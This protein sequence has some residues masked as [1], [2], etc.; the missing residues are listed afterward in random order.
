MNFLLPALLL[1]LSVF[2][3]TT[4]QTLV[5]ANSKKIFYVLS[6]DKDIKEG[7]YAE[8]NNFGNRL[9][10][11]GFY[12]NNQKDSLWKYY[13]FSNKIAETGFYKDDK[14]TG[15]WVVYNSKDKLE[16]Q[17]DYT[18]HKL[19]SYRPDSTISITEEV[20]N[21][22]DTIKKPLDQ[23]AIYMDGFARVSAQNIRYPAKAREDDIQGKVLIAFTVDALGGVSNFRVKKGI[24]GGCDEEALRVIK[25]M[26]GDWLP[27]IVNGKPVTI[28][29]TIPVSFTLK[30]R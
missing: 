22:Q 30:S 15:L 1:P 27:G 5:I 9:I 25:L 7:P 11:E 8:Y 14:K 23:P 3:Q 28:E 2:A 13:S 16:I 4:R 20:V 24:G 19:I 10:C 17:Y 26:D 21:G 18:N 12:K 6:S 29:C